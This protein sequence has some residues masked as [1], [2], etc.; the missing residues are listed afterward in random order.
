M[1]S[2]G[3]DEDKSKE[4][5]IIKD[6]RNL[7]RLSRLKMETNNAAMKGIR[8]LFR[9]KKENKGIKDRIIREIRNL[10]EQEEEDYYNQ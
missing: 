2:L 3:L 10:F 7:F 5:N 9:L 6:V 8:H 1:E 4:E